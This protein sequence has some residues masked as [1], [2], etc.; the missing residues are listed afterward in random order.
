MTVRCGI[1][2][3]GQCRVTNPGARGR[4]AVD[5]LQMPLA[6]KGTG[7]AAKV[8][9]VTRKVILPCDSH[10]RPLAGSS[11]RTSASHHGD[12]EVS[13]AYSTVLAVTK[14]DFMI[15]WP[16]LDRPSSQLP[17]VHAHSNLRC[18]VE[19]NTRIRV[20]ATKKL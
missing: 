20:A 16:L 13:Y 18:P 11:A 6:D 9:R 14:D 17:E 1:S 3:S 15:S 5:S 8:G 2:L 4:I 19:P 12:W 7:T 10:R